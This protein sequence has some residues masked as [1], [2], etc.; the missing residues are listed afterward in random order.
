[1]FLSFSEVASPAD[2][3]SGNGRG[4]IVQSQNVLDAAGEKIVSYLESCNIGKIGFAKLA[5]P[6]SHPYLIIIPQ[7]GEQN[8]AR[9]C[10]IKS[11]A[12]FPSLY[13]HLTNDDPETKQRIRDDDYIGV[14]TLII[15]HEDNSGQSGILIKTEPCDVHAFASQL[16]RLCPPSLSSKAAAVAPDV[17]PAP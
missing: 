4:N 7:T 8:P 11:G 14:K 6:E 16:S 9:D 12:C 15:L 2:L 3:N 10:L 1:M 13:Q 17:R 5:R